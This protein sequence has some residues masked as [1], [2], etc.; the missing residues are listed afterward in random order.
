MEMRTYGKPDAPAV[1]LLGDDAFPD[2]LA[3]IPEGLEKNY[4]LLVPAFDAAETADLR[5]EAL[6]SHLLE[7]FAGR[8]RGAYG[9]RG[10]ATL[11][12]SLL[13]HG[14]VRIG[15]S[16]LEGAFSLP[17]EPLGSGAGQI[18]C[19][20][21][22]KD[23][24][25]AAAKKALAK[26]VSTLSTLTM[27]KLRPEQCFADVRPDL[28]IKRLNAAF[29]PGVTVTVSTVFPQS[30]ERVWADVSAH[31]AGSAVTRI[32]QTEPLQRCDGE[33]VLVFNGKS[34]VLKRWSRL[35]RLESLGGDG[36]ILTD[37]VELDA[38]K[39]N[40]LA[41]PLAALYLK[42]LHARRRRALKKG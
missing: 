35:T 38:G 12:L 22:A 13:S 6:E 2:A 29:G 14:R 11:L 10:G 17:E 41:K 21:N 42:A 7:L 23:K 36:A 39:L 4:C 1:L 30:A 33:R 5:R 24:A 37:Q 20:V 9:L 31:P 28:M 15:V 27:K 34:G 18:H 19:W 40:A 32:T 3:D 8:I 26:Q 25:A 16:V